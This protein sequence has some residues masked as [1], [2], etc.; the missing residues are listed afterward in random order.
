MRSN[1]LFAKFVVTKTFFIM[2]NITT[3][4]DIF[5]IEFA[6]ELSLIREKERQKLPYNFNVIEELHVNENANTRILV[7]L[8]SYNTSGE[9]VFLKSFIS[10]MSHING[11]SFP[12]SQVCRPK[13]EYNKENIDCL[14]ED[15]SKQYAII[16]ENKINGAVDQD[17]QLLRY[18]DTIKQHGV[19][20]SN[21]YIIYLTLDGTKEVSSN[22]LPDKSRE[23]LGER[24]IKMNYKGHI[25]PWLE[26]YILP[27]IK[28]K[29][30]LIESGIRQYI[31]YL[32]G[33]LNL[34]KTEEKIRRIMNKTI[35]EK[36]LK[37]KNVCEQ[38]N[39]L[40]DSAS[41]LEALINDLN[42]A[43]D[44]IAQSVIDSWDKITKLFWEDKNTRTN[45]K[46]RSEDY[47]QI[48]FNNDIEE[49]IHF[50]WYPISKES[51]F[52]ELSYRMVL[53]VEQDNDKINM[54]K[55][56][57]MTELVDKAKDFNYAILF[58]EDRRGVDAIFKEYST[59]D[60]KSFAA[61]DSHEK[62]KFLEECYCE[63]KALKEIIENSFHKFDSENE[64][65][66]EL[67]STM[68][69]CTNSDWGIWPQGDYGWD[70]ATDFNRDTH[71]IGIE[72]S[73]G[74]NKGRK[75]EFRS[76]I[77][78]W[79]KYN[80]DIYEEHL[81]NKYH[82]PFIDKKEERVYLHLPVIVIGDDLWTWNDKKDSVVIHLK[83]TFDYMK[84]LTTEIG[85]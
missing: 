29:D 30:T 54:L 22:S 39:I 55:L 71:R 11:V 84:Q 57:R 28:I 31:D 8:L 56:S 48:F 21:I 85:R 3:Q 7:K 76:Y 43:S 4:D 58:D 17:N 67:C 65:I 59:P 51:L 60:N 73:F 5:W 64:I 74:V 75:I 46:L 12:L 18:F 14:I 35:A 47:Y 66:R 50:E 70:L 83:E 20:E 25:L 27:E 33:R 15:S 41:N 82:N 32:E 69:E 26:E 16:I 24:F 6:S 9:Y 78:V 34:R 23:N 38:W 42:N 2:D 37:D 45:N 79:E 44:Y 53:H 81:K 10:M 63:V 49:N 36:L 80:W 62:L 77:T 40:R 1:L 52:K 72:G 68:K 13:I 61:L 19:N